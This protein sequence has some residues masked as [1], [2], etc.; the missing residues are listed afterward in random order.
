MTTYHWLQLASSNDQLYT[1]SGAPFS[2]AKPGQGRDV[3]TAL[4]LYGYYAFSKSLDVQVGYS[5]FFFGQYF[6]TNGTTRGD[7]TQLYVQTTLRY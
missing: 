1:V 6:D 5:W 7:C 2:A 4:D 3:G